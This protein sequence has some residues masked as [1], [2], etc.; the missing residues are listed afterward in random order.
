MLQEI[1][2][3]SDRYQKLH[4]QGL[5]TEEIMLEMNKPVSM[6]IFTWDGEKQATMSAVDSIKHYLTFLQASLLALDPEQGAVRAWVGGINH[7]YF[8]YDHVRESTKRQVGSIIKP[9]VYAA[10]LEQGMRPCSFIS[11]EKTTYTNMEDW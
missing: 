2:E 6:N 3:K 8:Q 4:E 7:H 1:I 10:A 9:I 11:A 5:S